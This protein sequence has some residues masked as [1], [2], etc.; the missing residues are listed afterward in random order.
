VDGTPLTPSAA[1]REAAEKLQKL[2]P[3]RHAKLTPEAPAS[4]PFG[5]G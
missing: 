4:L 3:E 5:L 1:S 2:D